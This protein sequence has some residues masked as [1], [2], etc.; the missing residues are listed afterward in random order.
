MEVLI[1][2]NGRTQ[3]LFL[4]P[5]YAVYY[6]YFSLQATEPLGM[7]DKVRVEIELG[8]CDEQGPQADSFVAAQHIAYNKMIKACTS[9]TVY[10]GGYNTYALGV[11]VAWVQ[12]C[13]PRWVVR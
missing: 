11:V 7:E 6:R 8:I 2:R 10:W 3:Y 1:A 9:F 12:S 13:L 4:S 5:I